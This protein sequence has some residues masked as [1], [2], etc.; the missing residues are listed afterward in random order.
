VETIAKDPTTDTAPPVEP[1]AEAAMPTYGDVP[2]PAKP[3]PE[4]ASDP[5]PAPSGNLWTLNPD[6][7]L[8]AGK[9]TTADGDVLEFHRGEP[10]EVP[11]AEVDAISAWTYPIGARFEA[12]PEPNTF[13]AMRRVPATDVPVVVPYTAPDA[14]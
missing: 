13:P 2:A 12:N 8:D 1:D 5:L 4:P 10:T 14:T 6:L 7:R 3:E 9:H 11:P